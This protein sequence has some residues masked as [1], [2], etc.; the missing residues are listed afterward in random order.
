MTLVNVVYFV[1]FIFTYKH[2]NSARKMSKW[3]Y[4]SI[5]YFFLE[6]MSNTLQ[7]RGSDLS[8]HKGIISLLS[9]STYLHHLQPQNVR[10]LSTWVMEQNLEYLVWRN[11][12]RNVIFI[13]EGM[14]CQRR[15]DVS[16]DLFCYIHWPNNISVSLTVCLSVC[17]SAKK[18]W[19]TLKYE[20][21]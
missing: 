17:L 2:H 10:F 14:M 13:S 18:K 19:N 16:L 11:T 8:L 4:P 5:G 1:D 3:L 20:C 21:F 12:V 9:E 15:N 7:K 6:S